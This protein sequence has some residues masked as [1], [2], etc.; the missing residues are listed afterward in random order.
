MKRLVLWMS[1][2]AIAIGFSTCNDEDMPRF[3]FNANGECY[4][5]DARNISHEEFLKHAEGNGWKHVSC[6]EI[7]ED[8]KISTKSFY[9]G[10]STLPIGYIIE[11]D[12][13]YT[14]Q[15]SH[16]GDMYQKIAYVYLEDRNQIGWTGDH[17]ENSFYAKY[18]VISIDEKE[19]KMI[20]YKGIRSWD[21]PKDMYTLT[22]YRK[23]NSEELE[24]FRKGYDEYMNALEASRPQ[25]PYLTYNVKDGILHM[26]IIDYTINCGAEDVAYE[27]KHQDDGVVQVLITET[28]DASANC[29]DFTT[30]SFSVPDLMMGETYQFEIKAKSL[31][32]GV[33]MPVIEIVSIRLEEGAEGKFNAK[34]KP[35]KEA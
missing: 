17:Y 7:N 19:L 33:H 12:V 35:V 34:G 21:N 2:L 14:C 20:E 13:F 25:T 15:T 10:H 1:L 4:M 29:V 22:T 18:Q 5:P 28:G 9:E 11:E 26:E 27:F 30:L 24:S 23:M 32:G 3:Q 8:G 6:Y 31:G 16:L